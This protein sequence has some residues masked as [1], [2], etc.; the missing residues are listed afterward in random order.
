VPYRIDG[1]RAM[2]AAAPAARRL[3]LTGRQEPIAD[4][5][6]LADVLADAA[7]LDAAADTLLGQ[8]AAAAP[9]AL[10]Y[11]TRLVRALQRSTVDPEVAAGL[12]AERDRV[13]AGPDLAEA[14]AAR[15]EGRA[16]HFAQADR[17]GGGY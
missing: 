17:R 8:L 13:L 7:D 12:V 6:G 2:L 10:G 14:L 16:P 4:V 9:A 5:A 11:T 1:V 3:L 15:R